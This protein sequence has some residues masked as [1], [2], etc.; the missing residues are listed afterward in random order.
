MQDLLKIL[1]RITYPKYNSIYK[2][3]LKKYLNGVLGKAGSYFPKNF[4]INCNLYAR[5]LK[6]IA[7]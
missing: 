6:K 4:N 7:L 3:S 2:V 1:T 5:Q